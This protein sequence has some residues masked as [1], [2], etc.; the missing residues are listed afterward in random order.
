MLAVRTPTGDTGQIWKNPFGNLLRS[1]I[2]YERTNKLEVFAKFRGNKSI[3]LIVR[4]LWRV[5]EVESYALSKFQPPTM[6]GDHQNVEKR[7]GKKF[8]FWGSGK[9][10]FRNFSWI[11]EELNNFRRQ[12]QLQRQI[13]LRMRL[14]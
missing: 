2:T 12:S 11:L 9:S 6:D 10:V 14:F 8:D 5:R 13:L 3:S 1:A 7:F 4:A